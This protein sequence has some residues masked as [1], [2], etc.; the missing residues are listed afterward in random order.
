MAEAS[1]SVELCDVTDAT[2]ITIWRHIYSYLD[3]KDIVQG[4]L[5]CSSFSRELPSLVRGCI[6]PAHVLLWDH[7]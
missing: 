5:V 3:T 7:A 2:I 6:C 4:M 1:I